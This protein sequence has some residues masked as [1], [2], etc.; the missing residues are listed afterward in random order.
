MKYTKNNKINNKYNK[1][2]LKYIINYIFLVY[3][4]S[5]TLF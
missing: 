3:Q 2:I 1:L 5:N 4:L